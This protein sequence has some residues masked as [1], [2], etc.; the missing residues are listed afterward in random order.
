VA[1]GKAFAE[2]DMDAEQAAHQ[3]QVKP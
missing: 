1:I 2:A 3:K